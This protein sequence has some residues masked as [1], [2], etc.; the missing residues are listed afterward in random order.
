M[1]QF[2]QQGEEIKR[3]IVEMLDGLTNRELLIVKKIIAGIHETA[4]RF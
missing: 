2:I 3:D 1:V 4:P